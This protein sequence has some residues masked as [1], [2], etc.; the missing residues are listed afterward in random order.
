MG[1]EFYLAVVSM[2]RKPNDDKNAEDLI[3]PKIKKLLEALKGMTFEKSEIQEYY[4]Q[5]TGDFQEDEITPEGLQEEFEGVI[6][7]F[8]ECLDSR[9]IAIL[10]F[11]ERAVIMSGGLSYGDNPTDHYSTIERFSYLP[12][13]LLSVGDFEGLN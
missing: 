12:K 4:E 2:I 5:T 7:E 6:K 9:D 8:I 1:E 13:K 10:W 11:P 3:T